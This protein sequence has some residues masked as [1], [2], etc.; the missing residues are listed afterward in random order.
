MANELSQQDLLNHFSQQNQLLAQ[1]LKPM[2]KP[3]DIGQDFQEA[4]QAPQ[5][6]PI[7]EKNS[8]QVAPGRTDQQMNDQ[9][10]YM[11][12]K[13]YNQMRDNNEL[14]GQ[15]I[16]GDP[17]RGPANA[18]N[19][20][21]SAV[22]NF[23]NW[24]I[25]PAIDPIKNIYN[26]L[27]G[28]S[29]NPATTAIDS[30][31]T[32]DNVA[33]TA[34]TSGVSA[35]KF[36]QGNIPLPKDI[37]LGDVGSAPALSKA[38]EQVNQEIPPD[39]SQVKANLQN[40]NALAQK[41][42][43]QKQ[44][45][46]KGLAESAPYFEQKRQED[47]DKIDNITNQMQN[48]AKIDPN[49]LW[50]DNSIGGK[51]GFLV[52]ASFG[53]LQQGGAL[54]GLID[55]DIASQVRNIQNNM[56]NNKGLVSIFM[57]QGEDMATAV[58]NARLYGEKYIQAANELQQ[59]KG[60]GTDSE[61]SARASSLFNA[62]MKD[63]AT[64]NAAIGKDQAGV[65][66][67]QSEN[68]FHKA[69]IEAGNEK[70]KTDVQIANNKLNTPTM[71]E[72]EAQ[73]KVNTLVSGRNKLLVSEKGLNGVDLTEP[74][75]SVL[76]SLASQNQN[77][78]VTKALFSSLVGKATSGEK[79]SASSGKIQEYYNNAYDRAANKILLEGGRLTPDRIA[80]EIKRTTVSGVGN[81]ENF[82]TADQNRLEDINNYKTVPGKAA[83]K[84]SQLNK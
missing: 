76:G 80:N 79:K 24:Y 28:N 55:N 72:R 73:A 16:Q 30:G 41:E 35:P 38:E 14:P 25:K 48:I 58:Q 77:E 54:K 81:K 39:V 11:D 12:E 49:R 60:M 63:L 10:Q 71:P 7:A 66:K 61:I 67:M 31:K 45:Y 13:N 57:K 52:A 2:V 46:Y 4:P 32:S 40:E 15:G 75:S 68:N 22:N 27:V 6:E 43:Q 18:I 70:R 83:F 19:D 42:L 5:E 56:D 69:Q 78:S 84:E 50:N 3:E 74:L 59:A 62:S 34:D 37:Q 51:I 1:T 21:L 9:Q 29:S 20:T 23:G 33:Q 53:G 8:V 44:D 47:F 26:S 82:A 36:N 64:Q 65:A 17:S